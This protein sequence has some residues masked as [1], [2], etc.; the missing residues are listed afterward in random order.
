MAAHSD[1][2]TTKIELYQAIENLNRVSIELKDTKED[3]QYQTSLVQSS[4]KENKSIYTPHRDQRSTIQELCAAFKEAQ[5]KK[6]SCTTTSTSC[7]TTMDIVAL[8]GSV[9]LYPGEPNGD[10][11]SQLSWADNMENAEQSPNPSIPATSLLPLA[12]TVLRSPGA[13]DKPNNSPSHIDQAPSQSCEKLQNQ[14]VHTDTTRPKSPV[15]QGTP[16]EPVN[17]PI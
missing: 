8:I 11:P 4:F 1:L 7:Q 10:P 5:N 13:S 2:S 3:L 6:D 15:H 14:P 12:A 17:Q 16:R 9:Q